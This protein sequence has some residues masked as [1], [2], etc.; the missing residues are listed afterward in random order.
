MHLQKQLVSLILLEKFSTFFGFKLSILLFGATEQ[1]LTTLQY[2][3]ISAEDA[4]SSVNASISFLNRQQ[5]E[6]AF[7]LFYES[8]VLEA[9]EFTKDPVLPRPK[10][11]PR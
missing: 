2:K 7:H 5:N 6:R 8:M 9:K 11:V 3:D 10:K 4:L 1:T